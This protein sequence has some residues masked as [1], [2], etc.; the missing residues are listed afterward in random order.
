MH[1]QDICAPAGAQAKDPCADDIAKFCQDVKPGGGRIVKCLEQ[2]DKGMSAEWQEDS[3]EWRENSAE[4]REDSA[5]WR[6]K[7]TRARKRG[8]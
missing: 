2:N 5:E 6:E 8:E 1:H 7:L 3:A 4:W